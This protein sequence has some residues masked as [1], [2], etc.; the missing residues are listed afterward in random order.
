VWQIWRWSEYMFAFNGSLVQ[1]CEKKR[2]LKKMSKFLMVY[3]LE[4][5]GAIYFRSSICFLLKCRHLHS[6]FDLVR[7]RDY[8]ATNVCKIVHRSSCWYTHV[9]HAHPVFL[10]RTTHPCVLIGHILICA[11]GTVYFKFASTFSVLLCIH[12][13]ANY[14]FYRLYLHLEQN[15]YSCFGIN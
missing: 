6:K 5:A 7:T 11:N 9:V 4:M 3:I 1:V 2:K 8:E 13:A 10:G 12:S 15:S 14:L